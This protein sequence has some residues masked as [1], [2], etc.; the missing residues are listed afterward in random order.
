MT[1]SEDPSLTAC[2]S[3]AKGS[4]VE[5]IG[6]GVAGEVLST[7]DAPAGVA[8]FWGVEISVETRIDSSMK[9][10]STEVPSLVRIDLDGGTRASIET[11]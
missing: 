4:L 11:P 1:T 9:T 7:W 8:S 6:G 3:A 2:E 5:I 10:L